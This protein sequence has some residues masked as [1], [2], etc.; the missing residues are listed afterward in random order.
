MTT[1]RRGRRSR[2]GGG[3]GFRSGRKTQWVDTF[4]N[5]L[6][7]NAG[8]DEISLLLDLVGNDT[9][10]MTLTRTIVHLESSLDQWTGAF[11]IQRVDI[12]IGVTDQ[13][14]FLAG[15]MPDP[16][17]VTEEPLLGWVWRAQMWVQI[18]G[19]VS[20]AYVPSVERVDLSSRRKIDD[21][22]LYLSINNN[23]VAGTPDSV[24]VGGIV[25]SLFLLP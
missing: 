15:V 10:G 16:A 18:Q 3:R 1:T 21:G 20:A 9:M 6:V 4:V 19:S 13:E 22:E 14:A 12:A 25:R 2:R 11:G 24:R 7:P 5:C 8:A 23:A 17:V